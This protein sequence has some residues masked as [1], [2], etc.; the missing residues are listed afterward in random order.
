TLVGKLFIVPFFVARLIDL[1]FFR[2]AFRVLIF[3]VFTMGFVVFCSRYVPALV[4]L[5]LLEL[6]YISPVVGAAQIAIG[7]LVFS[8][9]ERNWVLHKIKQKFVKINRR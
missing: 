1:G 9:S 4:R 5:T 2:L 3:V 8:V 7:S 6:L